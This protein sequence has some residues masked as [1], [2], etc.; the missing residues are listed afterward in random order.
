MDGQSGRR[1]CVLSLVVLAAGLSS[2]GPQAGVETLPSAGETLAQ[3]GKRLSQSRSAGELT[4]MAARGD[5]VLA[6][7]NPDERDALG[8]NALRFRI[9]RPAEVYVAVPRG[10]EPFWLADQGFDASGPTLSD[11]DL[12][13]SVY[14]KSFPAG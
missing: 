3:A 9:D 6:A 8:R 12:T 14:R 13:W 10:A 11:G 4:K 5:R 7:L 1:R 2:C